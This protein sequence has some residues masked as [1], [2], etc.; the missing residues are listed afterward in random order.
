VPPVGRG[1]HVITRQLLS[2]MGEIEEIEIGLA[3]FF[4]ELSPS[5]AN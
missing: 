5:L 3:N 2:G 4:S 1:C